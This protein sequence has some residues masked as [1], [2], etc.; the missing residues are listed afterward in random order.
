MPK[1]YS[2]KTKT[3]LSQNLKVWITKFRITKF[4]ITK[5]RIELK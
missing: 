5:G 1:S 2:Y 3:C 4:K